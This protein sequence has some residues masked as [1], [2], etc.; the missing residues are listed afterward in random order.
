MPPA[1]RRV[2]RVTDGL[3]LGPSSSEFWGIC[4]RTGLRA[5]RVSPLRVYKLIVYK[6]SRAHRTILCLMSIVGRLGTLA[7]VMRTSAARSSTPPQLKRPF[8][9][10]AEARVTSPELSSRLEPSAKRPRRASQP[11]SPMRSFSHSSSSK[12]R[13]GRRGGGGA[14]GAG[15]S[16]SS[17]QKPHASRGHDTRR[18]LPADGDPVHDEAWMK[19]TYPGISIKDAWVANPKSTVFNWTQTQ[20][21]ERPEFTH[22]SVLLHGHSGFRCAQNHC[23]NARN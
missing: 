15:R 12:P 22:E 14:R 2:S 4:S 20:G 10:A 17:Q 9:A 16:S 19:S 11:T 18:S 3:A 7:R 1:Q 23:M 6:S 8:S 21:K 13:G 5:S